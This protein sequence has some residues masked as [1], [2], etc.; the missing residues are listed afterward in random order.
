MIIEV[1]IPWS[2]SI[3]RHKIR[4]SFRPFILRVSR[5]HA[6]QAHTNTL[7]ILNRRPSLLTEKIQADDSVRVDV[8]VHGDWAIGK[9]D[10]GYFWRF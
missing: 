1:D 2:S 3:V 10:E 9:E 8:W 5:Q 4:I 6:L 7:H